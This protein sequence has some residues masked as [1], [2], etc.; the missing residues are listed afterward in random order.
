MM[1]KIYIVFLIAAVASMAL[2]G[3]IALATPPE[4]DKK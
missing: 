3:A 4:I 2:A 1:T